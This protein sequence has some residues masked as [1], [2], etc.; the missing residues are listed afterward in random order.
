MLG[1]IMDPPGVGSPLSGSGAPA[2]SGDQCSKATVPL[3]SLAARR[4][5]RYPETKSPAEAGLS[6]QTEEEG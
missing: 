6:Q 2:A 1:R 4:E 3:C 5:P